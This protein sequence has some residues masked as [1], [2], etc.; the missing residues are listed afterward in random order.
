MRRP[1]TVSGV[2]SLSLFSRGSGVSR[3]NVGTMVADSVSWTY[4][5]GHTTIPISQLQ[6]LTS[7]EALTAA[8]HAWVERFA[9]VT[10]AQSMVSIFSASEKRI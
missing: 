7:P 8:P 3:L 6:I 5:W 4:S 9:D 2:V 10:I 1:I